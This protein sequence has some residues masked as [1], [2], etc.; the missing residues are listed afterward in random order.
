MADVKNNNNNRIVSDTLSQID[1]AL[2]AI[3]ELGDKNDLSFGTSFTANPFEMCVELL[4]RLKGYDY[5]IK[6]VA[7]LISQFLPFIEAGVKTVMVTHL[8]NMFTC[9]GNP[10]IT[11]EILLKGFT[12]DLKKIDVMNILSYSPLS[13]KEGEWSLILNTAVPYSQFRVGKYYYF[14]CDKMDNVHDLRSAGDFNAFLW[15]VKNKSLQREVWMGVNPI[16]AISTDSTPKLAGFKDINLINASESK[17]SYTLTQIPRTYPNKELLPEDKTWEE[18]LSNYSK[19]ITS[20]SDGIL[21][22][23]YRERANTIEDCEGKQITEENHPRTN[24]LQVFIGNVDTNYTDEDKNRVERN[25]REYKAELKKMKKERDDKIREVKNI[26]DNIKKYTSELKT[27]SKQAKQANK[28]NDNGET[29]ETEAQTIAKNKIADAKAQ[30]KKKLEEIDA[31]ENDIYEFQKARIEDNAMFMATNATYRKPEQNYFYLHPMIEWNTRYIASLKLFDSKVVTSQLIDA[32]TG[33]MSIDLQFSASYAK[34][35]LKD[36]IENIVKSVIETD[37]AVISDCFFAFSNE[38]YER[39]LHK[40]ELRKAGIYTKDGKENSSVIIT[41]KSVLEELD[42]L[43]DDASKEQIETIIEGGI[44]EISKSLSDNEYKSKG[45][46]EYKAEFNFIENL[47]TNLTYV[48]TTAVLSPKMYMLI[49]INMQV[50]GEQAPLT[51]KDFI[52]SNK[53]MIVDIVREIKDLVMKWI[54]DK[55][56]EL[57]GNITDLLSIEIA[58]EQLTYYR[59]LLKKMI[60]CFKRRKT[61]TNDFDVAD[62]DYADIYGEDFSEELENIEC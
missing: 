27:A 6:F 17:N 9:S 23:Q 58:Q 46:V 25:L 19:Y 60:N 41:A 45:K 33:C 1:S 52:E 37:D 50:V 20:W 54:R 36:E 10:L 24:C 26:Q 49:A 53:K 38:D 31:I 61:L 40:A 47:L 29:V 3:N 62:V 51:M 15:Y 4:K 12:L 32:L 35:M 5:I 13:G 2:L 43:S 34:E 8:A 42:N 39:M 56:L 55:I 22:V 21:T 30:E 18:I 48:I 59:D 57:V 28:G 44:R 14:G 11:K 7:Q 16:A